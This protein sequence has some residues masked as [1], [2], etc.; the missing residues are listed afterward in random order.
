[1][2]F[3]L[4]GSRLKMRYNFQK[5]SREFEDNKCIVLVVFSATGEELQAPIPA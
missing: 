1:M 3:V 4:E 5:T 2:Y